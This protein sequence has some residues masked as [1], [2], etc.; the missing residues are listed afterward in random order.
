MALAAGFLVLPG[1]GTGA[2]GFEQN[3]AP[4]PQEDYLPIQSLGEEPPGPA[5]ELPQSLHA[6][7]CLGR[8]DTYDV[9]TNTFLTDNQLRRECVSPYGAG[10]DGAD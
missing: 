5:E 4:A 8:Y 7:W 2:L 10:T 6:A 3:A 9:G 1:L